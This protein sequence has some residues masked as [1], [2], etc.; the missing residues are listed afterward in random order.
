MPKTNCARTLSFNSIIETVAAAEVMSPPTLRNTLDRFLT[1]GEL[2]APPP[3][4]LSLNDPEHM[5][6]GATGPPLEVQLD[7]AKSSC[8]WAGLD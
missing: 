3:K 7:N 2:E 1:T 4:R 6:F 8:A 5:R